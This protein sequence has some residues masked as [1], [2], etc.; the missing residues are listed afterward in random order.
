MGVIISYCAALI[1]NALGMTN[2]DGS[3]ILD[4][5]NIAAASWI[6]VPAFSIC[7]FNISAILVMAP[8]AL[9]TMMEHIGS[10]FLWHR[11]PLGR[12]IS[13]RN[14]RYFLS[15]LHRRIEP[16]PGTQL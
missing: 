2:A 7:K 15:R 9:A 16:D 8:I 1:F 14:T 10:L 4:F 6:G 11:I 12:S 13:G 5:S 3:A